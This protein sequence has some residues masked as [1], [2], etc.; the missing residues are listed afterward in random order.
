MLMPEKGKGNRA[1]WHTETQLTGSRDAAAAAAAPT[2]TADE[3]GKKTA[4]TT[5]L[6]LR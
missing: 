4:T 1:D 2:T 3:E 6:P 5:S